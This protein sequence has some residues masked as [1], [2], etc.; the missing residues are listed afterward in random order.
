MGQRKVEAETRDD[1]RK[2]KKT[3]IEERWRQVRR[4]LEESRKERRKD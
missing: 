2:G 3:I 1:K 4:Q